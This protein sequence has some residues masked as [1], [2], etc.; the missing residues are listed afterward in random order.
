MRGSGIDRRDSLL[1]TRSGLQFIP[2]ALELLLIGTLF[3]IGIAMATAVG[4]VSIDGA[5][6]VFKGVVVGAIA[7]VA[8]VWIGHALV[9][10]SLAAPAPGGKPAKPPPPAK[11]DLRE[12]RWNAFRSLTIVLPVALWFL[13]S[14]ASA[15]FM[16]VMIKVASM[17]QQATNEGARF[18][19]RSLIMSTIIG[20]IGAIIGW[21][22][23]DLIK[24]RAHK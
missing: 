4:T 12:A 2:A 18:A 14:S 21:N 9:P 15:A 20:G 10:D 3:T 7:G 23:V 16:P 22:T 17:G 13:F 5:L 6:L 8:F 24:G 11:P 1:S 19:G